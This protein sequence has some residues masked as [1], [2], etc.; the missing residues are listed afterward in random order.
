M[1]CWHQVSQSKCYLKSSWRVTL[2]LLP[3]SLS[4]SISLPHSLFPLSLNHLLFSLFSGCSKCLETAVWAGTGPGGWP[5]QGT[6]GHGSRQACSQHL[7]IRSALDVLP[8]S[9]PLWIWGSRCACVCVRTRACERANLGYCKSQVLQAGPSSAPS[10]PTHTR[11]N[12]S[13]QHYSSIG[14]Q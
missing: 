3:P 6:V 4:L 5:H 9:Q 14:K 2:T 10:P 8:I 7:H 1:S 12:I 11:P 13:A